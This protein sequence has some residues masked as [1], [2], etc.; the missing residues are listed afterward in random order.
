[1]TC[2]LSKGSGRAAVG[3]SGFQRDDER[4]RDRNSVTGPKIGSDAN[5]LFELCRS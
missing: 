3:R 5:D 2:G 1:M 4:P